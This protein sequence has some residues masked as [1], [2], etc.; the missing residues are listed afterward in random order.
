M[1]AYLSPVFGAGAQ[2]FSDVGIV[3]SG[4]KIHTYEAGTTTPSATWTDSTQ[5]V[6]NANPIILDSTGRLSNEMWLQGGSTYKFVL[7]DSNNNILGTWDNIAGLND[8]TASVTVN[9]WTLTKLTPTYISSTSFSVP[10]NNVSIFDINRRLKIVVSAGTIYGYVVSSTFSTVTTV[11]I[12]P[13]ST[14]LDSGISSVSVGLLDASHVSVPQQFMAA[15]APILLTAATTTNIG[16]ALSV[17]ITIS[18]TT[19][20]TAFDTVLAGI[21]RFVYWSAATPIVYNVTSMQLISSVSRTNNAGDFSVFCSLGSG[22][23]IEEIYQQRTGNISANADT[24]TKAGIPQNSQST[25]YTTVLL[26]ANKN[27]HHPATDNNARL[28]TIDSNVNVAY[29]IGT[30]LLFTNEINIL[31]I[32][33][34]SD[35]LSWSPTGATG[36]RTLA[37]NGIAAAIKVTATKWM[38]SGVGLT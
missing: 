23:W 27:I 20:I 15:N 17:N 3:L 30:M 29:P 10:G 32:A 5:A 18:G 11:V 28:F 7:A 12:Q 33:I 9:E 21:V 6:A 16:A 4:G 14:V 31:T 2:L 37:G 25:A 34:T 38:I 36:S 13:D 26:D 19:S 1:A 24:A 8:I 35:T 22:N